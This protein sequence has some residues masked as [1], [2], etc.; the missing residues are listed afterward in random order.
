MTPE[1][2]DIAFEKYYKSSMRYLKM[3]QMEDAAMNAYLSLKNNTEKYKKYESMNSSF[4]DRRVKWAKLNELNYNKRFISLEEHRE[5]NT[6]EFSFEDLLEGNGERL[7]ESNIDNID[8]ESK[9]AE[10]AC[11]DSK[12][13]DIMKDK[14][15][16]YSQNEISKKHKKSKSVI[17]RIVNGTTCLKRKK[18]RTEIDKS[19][20]DKF[21]KVAKKYGE[22]KGVYYR[23]SYFK[24]GDLI[25]N[26]NGVIFSNKNFFNGELHKKN[27]YINYIDKVDI[28]D[29]E[30]VCK[31]VKI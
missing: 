25:I 15:D 1:A 18:R 23:I 4:I 26:K 17:S 11:R 30:N 6:R 24:K 10:M 3:N 20:I 19:N 22:D 9:V 12:V 27:H 2:I 8:L 31:E 7:V 21:L 28:K 14:I 5:G 16:G 13:I 29:F